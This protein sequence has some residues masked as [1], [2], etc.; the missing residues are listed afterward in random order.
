V[1]AVPNIVDTAIG[2]RRA[3]MSTGASWHA[4][5]WVRDSYLHEVLDAW[6]E[7]EVRPRLRGSAILVRYADDAIMLFK[8][9][10]EAKRVMQ[11]LPK[12]FGRYGRTLHP[13]NTRRVPMQRPSR[14]AE[15]KGG[16]RAT[17]RSVD[18]FGFTHQW[19]KPYRGY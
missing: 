19:V 11:V 18:F 4:V 14:S 16:P 5:P 6:F 1:L 15:P 17:P 9:A 3:Q 12:R 7:R 8:N 13:D 2:A 10:D